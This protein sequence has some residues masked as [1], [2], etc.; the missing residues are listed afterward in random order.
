MQSWKY[1][2]HAMIPLCPPHEMPN[3]ALV[4]DG[5]IWKNEKKPL[6]VRYTTDFDCPMETNWWYVI[7]DTPFD[8]SALNAKR[9]YVITKA[10]RHF[11]VRL[12]DP[13]LYKEALYQVQVDAFSAYPE[14]YRPT[15][16]KDSFFNELDRDG[17]QQDTIKIW[18]AFFRETNELC[19]YVRVPVDKK[20]AELQVLKTKPQFER[21]QVNAALVN[22]VLRDLHELLRDGGYICDGAR[23]VVHETAFQ[24]YLEK[25]FGFRKAYCRLHMEYNPKFKWVFFFLYKLRGLFKKLDHIGL[26]HK[27]NGMFIM[28][29]IVDTDIS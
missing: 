22:G 4:R 25:Y 11:E 17:Q 26:V 12:I 16:H 7:K 15:V 24:D 1:Y 10:D 14:K 8:M 6:F 23:S 18:G 20:Y 2:N 27:M 9:R 19:G 29:E 13:S 28:Q 3:L 5:T 21:Y